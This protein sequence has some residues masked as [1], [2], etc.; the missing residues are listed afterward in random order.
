MVKR[1]RE[2]DLR[3]TK[4]YDANKMM[5]SVNNAKKE[6]KALTREVEN[7]YTFFRTGTAGAT[8]TG[9]VFLTT[10]ARVIG[11]TAGELQLL[12]ESGGWSADATSL[13]QVTTGDDGNQRIGRKMYCKQLEGTL[14][15]T[16]TP[17]GDASVEQH[18]ICRVV[19]V[20]DRRPS[21]GALPTVVN[22]N[23]DGDVIFYNPN[24]TDNLPYARFNVKSSKRYKILYDKV[25]TFNPA[26]G[27]ALTAGAGANTGRSA[28]QVKQINI[29]KKLNFETTFDQS[30]N[31]V[32]G[33]CRSNAIIMAAGT[34]S[35]NNAVTLTGNLCLTFT[36]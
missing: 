31:G 6:L 18:A 29:K 14:Q 24:V 34:S 21:A 15:V 36:G 30:T 33:T 26:P 1:A 16:F 23:G 5:K 8:T 32:Y 19:I 9:S 20:Q 3:D 35:T 7:K 2:L 4:A 27:F 28:I 13:T 12:T 25:I 22:N 10:A 17:Q 11:N